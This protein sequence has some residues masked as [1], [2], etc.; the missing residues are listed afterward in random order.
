M[1]TE[2][3]QLSTLHAQERLLEGAILL[4]VRNADEREA[5]FAP[6]STFIPLPELAERTGE[7]DPA[8]EYVVACRLGGRSQAAC[9]LLAATGFSVS[10]LDGGMQAWEAAGLP[11]VDESGDIGHII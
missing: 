8:A 1:T 9:E 10:N 2:I 6:G 4:D 5:G 11:V 3:P 7:L